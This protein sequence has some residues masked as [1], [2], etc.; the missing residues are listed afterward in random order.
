MKG[1]MTQVFYI[2]PIKIIVSLENIL[3]SFKKF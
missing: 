3:I 2:L 1:L